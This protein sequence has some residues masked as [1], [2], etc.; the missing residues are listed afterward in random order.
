MHAAV[1]HER[2]AQLQT[3]AAA[4]YVPPLSTQSD[5]RRATRGLDFSTHDPS[6]DKNIESIVSRPGTVIFSKRRK[7]SSF[8][9]DDDGRK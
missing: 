3:P 7:V 6:Y 1:H 9:H 5:G 8:C 4:T 2:P